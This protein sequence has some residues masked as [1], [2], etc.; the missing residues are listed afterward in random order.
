HLPAGYLALRKWAVG[1]TLAAG[2]VGSIAPDLDILWFY[3]VDNRATHHHEYITHR[4]LVWLI[5][6]VLAFANIRNRL[7]KIALAF[8]LGGLLHMMLDTIAG[9]IT[10]GW[11]FF[12][13]PLTLVHVPATHSNWI[14][15]FLTHWTFGIEVLVTLT[16]AGFAIKDYTRR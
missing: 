8:G 12:H 9:S 7:G 10:W 16:A 1:T 14:I 5:I 13:E 3:F 11:P 4:P 2:L 6:C 15:S